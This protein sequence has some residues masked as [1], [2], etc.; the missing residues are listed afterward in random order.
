M[1]TKPSVKTLRELFESAIC[2]RI[3]LLMLQHG[4]DPQGGDVMEKAAQASKE[5]EDAKGSILKAIVIM[6]SATTAADAGPPKQ[7]TVSKSK[8]KSRSSSRRSKAR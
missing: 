6:E 7:K 3:G 5:I 4:I 2:A 1:S 8:G